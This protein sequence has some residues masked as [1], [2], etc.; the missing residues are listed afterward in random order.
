[1]HT[2]GNT[3]LITGGGTGI[4]LGLAKAF[5]AL[6]NQIVIAGRRRDILDGVAKNC[7][8]MASYG[9]DIRNPDEIKS[10][11]AW[12]SRDFPALNMLINNAGVMKAENLLD[13]SDLPDME[14]IIETNL[15]GPM[16]LTAALLPALLTQ[17]KAAIINVS[18]GLGF[19]PMA[20]TPTYSA[21]KAALHSYTQCLRFQ[22]RK[23]K[24]KVVE[25]IPP[26]VATDLMGGASDPHAMPLD[27]FIAEVMELIKSHPTAT[28]ICVEN[29]K[30]LRY[31][32]ESIN[33]EK[34]FKTLNGALR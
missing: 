15:M 7:P 4:G 25:L 6:G 14:A 9:I 11:A 17:P 1:M 28:E 23:T 22:L 29:V 18:S 32:G 13:Q 5:H 20:S 31:A 2:K 21:T 33:Y 26:Y 8:G 3:I 12:L 34:I 24:I 10:F 27:A 16:R 30:H 19:V